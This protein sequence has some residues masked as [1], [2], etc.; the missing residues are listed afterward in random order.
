MKVEIAIVALPLCVWALA[1][2]LVPGQPDAKKL[3]FF[4]AGT[5]L[6]LTIVVELVHLVGISQDERGLQALPCKPG[7]SWR[8]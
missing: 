2:L 6:L 7:C 1:L 5:G 4:M 8:W 3:L